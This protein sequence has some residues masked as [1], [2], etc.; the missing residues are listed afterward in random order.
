MGAD[1]ISNEE[2]FFESMKKNTVYEYIEM[3]DSL[4]PDG[5]ENKLI[6]Y[7]DIN[8]SI[9]ISRSKITND[10]SYYYFGL[11]ENET[12]EDISINLVLKFNENIKKTN[13]RFHKGNVFISC[14]IK[15]NH[16]EIIEKLPKPYLIGK[17]GKYYINLGKLGETTV[18]KKIEELISVFDFEVTLD[19]DFQI[20]NLVELKQQNTIK[21]TDGF[22]DLDIIKSNLKVLK[23]KDF[24]NK[25]GFNDD[26]IYKLNDYLFIKDDHGNFNLNEELFFKSISLENIFDLIYETIYELDV[27]SIEQ[28]KVDYNVKLQIFYSSIQ[29]PNKKNLILSLENDTFSDDENVISNSEDVVG[30]DDEDMISNSED[31]VGSDDEDMISNSEDVVGSDD[32]EIIPEK[33]LVEDVDLDENQQEI[34]DEFIILKDDEWIEYESENFNISEEKLEVILSKVKMDIYLNKITD[35]DDFEDVLIEYFEQFYLD[36]NSN[37][38]IKTYKKI[39]NS[40]FYENLLIN[41]NLDNDDV[42]DIKYKIELDMQS[43]NLDEQDIINRFKI[44]FE[45]KFH[46][47]KYKS[48]LKKIDKNVYIAELNLTKFEIDDVINDVISRI[49]NW[50]YDLSIFD[51]SCEFIFNRYLNDKLDL[52]RSNTRKEFEKRYE[53]KEI[54]INIL[55]V[56]NISDERYNRLIEDIYLDINELVIRS[57][58]VDD[59]LLREYF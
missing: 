23:L 50:Y 2:K 4:V 17:H 13:L 48:K 27:N 38:M 52:I 58:N 31:V 39:I 51:K 32:V 59:N 41:Y 40:P 14:K 15:D 16:S 28:F 11:R 7:Y 56:Q 8:N 12:I 22:V 55:G 18:L 21:L 29:F 53:T 20:N 19:K 46:E 26:L 10:E 37:S 54:I 9:W 3:D 1:D 6:R 33:W 24:I 42:E 35:E 34:F 47:L 43:K 49:E 36:C 57:E 25:Q 45:C 30:S 5:H 44:Y